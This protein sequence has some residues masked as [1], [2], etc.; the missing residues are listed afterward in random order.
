MASEYSLQGY[1]LSRLNPSSLDR[2]VPV[3]ECFGFRLYQSRKEIP[4]KE[5][6]MK[7]FLALVCVLL[8]AVAS[9]LPSAKSAAIP[10]ERPQA[11]VGAQ[12]IPIT[13]APIQDG[14]LVVARGKIVA[15]GAR[16]Y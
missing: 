14:V 3:R 16:D 15:V 7:S 5:K 13:G 1:W 9:T 8:C 2:S 11:F 12:V 4:S 6:Q 10:Q